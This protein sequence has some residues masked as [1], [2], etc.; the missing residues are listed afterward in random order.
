MLN[1]KEFRGNAYRLAD[2]LPWVCLIAPGV[3]LNK[4]GSFQR[5]IRYRGPDLDS[6]TEAE[7]MSVA[8]RV[9]NVLKRFGSGWALFFDATRIPASEYPRSEFPDAVSWLV[10]EERRAAF[11]GAA[12]A[13][14]EDPSRPGGQHFESVLHLTLMYLPPA[15]R[16]SRLES[17]FLERPRQ[18]D[19]RV[20]RNRSARR[21]PLVSDAERG[22]EPAEANIRDTQIEGQNAERSEHGYR[23]HLQQFVQ[24]TDRAIDLLSSVLPEIWPLNDTE[25]L[26]Y[27]HSCVS[28]KRH[29]VSVPE[30]PAYL[31]CFLSD[32]PLTGGLSPAIGRSH[33]RALTVLG[34]PHIT[35]PGLLDELNRLGVAYRWAT[36]FLPLDRIQANAALSRYRRQWFAKRKSLAAILKEVM[37]NEQAALLDTDAS[38][39]ALDA[40]AAL[41]ELG[42]DLVSFGYITTTVTVSD[43]DSH[44]A[45]EKIRAVERVINNR[46]FTTIRESVN[47]VEA[48]LGGLPGQAYAN[49]RQPIVHTLN[50]AHMCPLSAVWAG[51]ERCEHLD[52]PPLLIAKTKGATPFRLSLY[53]GDVGHSIVVGPTGA[54]KSVLL[55]MLALQFR[56]YPNAQLITFDKGRSARATTLA[57]SGVW[58]ELGAKGGIAFQPLKDV[59]EEGPRLWA[60]DWLCGVLAHER[61][62][63]TPELKETIWSALTSLGTAPVPQRTITGLVA[64][65]ARDALRQAL[66]PYTLEG[67]YGRFLDAD[68]DHLSSADVVT[69]EMEELMALPHLVAP[70]LTYL[71]H[72]LEARFDGRPTLLVLD[73]AWV[74]LDDPLFSNRIRE[75]LKTLRKKNVAVIFATQSLADIADSEIAPAIIESCPSRIFLPNSRALEPTQTETYRRFGLNDT[76]VRLIAEAFP[77]RDY[78][79]QSRAG[80]RMFELGLGPVALALVGASSPE[81]QRVIEAVVSRTGPH[82]FGERYL[83]ERGLHWAANLISTFEQAH[84]V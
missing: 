81:D 16:V 74:F 1:L 51:P 39:K 6:A 59:A 35:F 28:T 14:W 13:T 60:L 57:L 7:L 19:L 46:G 21:G 40:D 30:I 22:K 84:K 11:A 17:L 37:F 69:F 47:A 82:H 68:A 23:E 18:K 71:F 32:E 55:S 64:L 79:L 5:T 9:N 26:T 12:G 34:F 43:E 50:L 45:D 63:M 66:Q 49:I 3:I 76:Q 53:A 29:P 36:R 38:N 61:V 42:D 20:R 80:N 62:T 31:D 73:E 10:D 8:S 48:W 72:A 4:D 52:G 67:P 56:R 78:Y 83:T 44:Q 27:L 54:G 24:E 33:L 2:W 77:K 65:L 75:W 25:T 15:E 70:V 58:Y 41:S